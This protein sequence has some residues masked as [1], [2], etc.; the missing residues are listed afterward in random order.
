MKGPK[1][2]LLVFTFMVTASCGTQSR[3]P[4]VSTPSHYSIVSD[5]IQN[6]GPLVLLEDLDRY[7]ELSDY[8]EQSL[9]VDGKYTSFTYGQIKQLAE[10]SQNNVSAS[11][12]FD[13]LLIDRQE[14]T[15]EYLS[16]C[17][18]K[19]IGQYYRENIEEHDYL[20]EII[21][22]SFFTDVDNADYL[23]LKKLNEEFENSDLSNSI[24]PIYKE[25]RATMLSSIMTD[26][27]G[28]F[29]TEE[30]VLSGM[31]AD[32]RFLLEQYIEDGVAII[33]PELSEKIDR[34][35]FKKIF[36]R[37]EMDNFSLPKYTEKLISEHLNQEYIYERVSKSVIDFIAV[38]TKYRK[39]Y[40]STY[41]DDW[42][43]CQFY[44]ISPT[45][46]DDYELYMDID[47]NTIQ[48][49]HATRVINSVI[50]VSSLVATFTPLAP[51]GIALDALDMYNGVTEDGKVSTM[52]ETV[53][54]SLYS[55]SISSVDSY[56]K[57]VF[58]DLR[59]E[60][61]AT[62]DFIIKRFY[63]DF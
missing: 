33:I 36:K 31:E 58:G 53:S 12:F 15:I 62:K 32:L 5:H 21:K 37:K 10:K 34:N 50:S 51:A 2:T 48:R 24:T 1:A 60:W 59:H 25:V 30:E 9:L 38:S 26:L 28:L 55:D 46:M 18:L 23:T 39:D 47:R 3:V 42:L 44:Y 11:V 6:A 54:N 49:I 40:L 14:K 63:E 45:L 20:K 4:V 29:T 27:D 35:L 43:S 17:T 16:N 41:M 7:P 22:D 13:S 61:L 19:E 52:M 8:I 56:I 57:Q